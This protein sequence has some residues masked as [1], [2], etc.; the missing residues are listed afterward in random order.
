MPT[1]SFEHLHL[2]ALSEAL[3][4]GSNK[5][6]SAEVVDYEIS[7]AFINI[8]GI[9]IPYSFPQ[10]FCTQ[11]EKETLHPK[12]HRLTMLMTRP[13]HLQSGP[14]RAAIIAI[15]QCRGIGSPPRFMC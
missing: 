10:T 8:S 9:I 12:K 11:Q 13:G 6:T 4:M 3:G 2:P 7:R 5:E 15:K 14:P 1:S